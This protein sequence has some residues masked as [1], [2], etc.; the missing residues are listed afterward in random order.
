MI[1]SSR[2]LPAQPRVT[3]TEAITHNVDGRVRRLR[4]C[5]Q[6]QRSLRSFPGETRR[7]AGER[8]YI[9]A[10]PARSTAPSGVA[11]PGARPT[12]AEGENAT[13]SETTEMGPRPRSPRSAPAQGTVPRHACVI[14]T[15][16]RQPSAGGRWRAEDAVSRLPALFICVSIAETRRTLTS[17]RRMDLSDPRDL[18]RSWPHH[19]HGGQSPTASYPARRRARW[20][21]PRRAGIAR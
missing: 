12:P 10:A 5:A 14:A 11:R 1:S 4:Q 18:R 21:L 19:I 15:A 8:M 20:R 17:E 7:P 16:R 9:L 3:C 2:A 6:N 13:R